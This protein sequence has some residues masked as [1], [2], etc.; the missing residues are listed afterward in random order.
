[1]SARRDGLGDS[2]DSV[3]GA[4]RSSV[5]SAPG[6]VPENAECQDERW[7]EVTVRA[8]VDRYID[9]DLIRDDLM[10]A[11]DW[12]NAVS[13]WVTD[14]SPGYSNDQPSPGYAT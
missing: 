5:G 4:G 6:P 13:A 10:A 12:D 14:T 8:Q 7:V 1:M 11:L 2:T 3:A 9:P